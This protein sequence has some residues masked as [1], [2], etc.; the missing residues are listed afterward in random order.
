[1]YAYLGNLFEPNS[2][3]GPETLSGSEFFNFD[4]VGVGAGFHHFDDCNL[5][6]TRLTERLR[7]GGTLFILDFAPHEPL[8]NHSHGAHGVKYNGFTEAQVR[9]IFDQ[10]GAGKD[11][12][13][14]M[15]K[16]KFELNNAHTEGQTIRREMFLA[17]GTKL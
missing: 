8:H 17:R 11:F 14:K 9:G 6:A 16:T 12:V 10:A 2:P 1:M 15:M 13:F 5:A 3:S 7:V 4:A